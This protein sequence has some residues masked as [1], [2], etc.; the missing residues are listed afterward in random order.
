VGPKGDPG[1][2]GTNGQ[3]G[4]AGP[5]D[6]FVKSQLTNTGLPG[7]GST[8]TILS[9]DLGAGTYQL[10]VTMQ[11]V[12]N[13]GTTSSDIQCYV[14][15]APVAINVHVYVSARGGTDDYYHIETLQAQD[16]LTLASPATLNLK[17]LLPS[18]NMRGLSW[19]ERIQMHALRVG[20]STTL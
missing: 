20:S 8:V 19:V 16:S 14:D 1:T 9:M 7:D 6:L 12:N 13:S 2:P 4:Q 18:T 17:C 5:S 15:G 10:S 3:D 11:A